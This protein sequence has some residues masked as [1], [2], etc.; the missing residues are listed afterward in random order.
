MSP[1]ELAVRLRSFLFGQKA[2]RHWLAELEERLRAS[3]CGVGVDVP[4]G[5]TDAQI[6]EHVCHQCHRRLDEHV[7]Q[8]N[9][10]MPPGKIFLLDVLALSSPPAPHA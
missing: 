2:E 1:A 10:M 5:I 7:I 6:A 4:P 9:E 3:G 8:R